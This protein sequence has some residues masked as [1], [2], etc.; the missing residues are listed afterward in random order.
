M[1]PEGERLRS[2]RDFKLAY[3]KGTACHD[4]GLSLH[5]LLLAD[6]PGDRL[7]GFAVSEKVGNAVVRNRVRRRLRE[8]FRALSPR[9]RTGF[10][11]VITARPATARATYQ[12][13]SDSLI[14]A[15]SR[16]G[17]LASTAPAD[18]ANLVS[19]DSRG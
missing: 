10:I 4:G 7:V 1:L 2:G 17:L 16:A 9:V 11:L 8:A 18:G 13:L 12:A 5:V 19:G 6:R 15:L 14:R 3:S